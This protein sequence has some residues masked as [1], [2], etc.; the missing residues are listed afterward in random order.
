MEIYAAMI[1]EVDRH[2]GR[3]VDHLE[4]LGVADNTVIIFM[5]DNGPEG[6]DLDETWPMEAYPEIRTTIDAA[7]DFSYET[8][9]RPGSYVLYGPNWANAGSPAYRLHK[10][11]PTEGGT[12]VAAFVYD[13][14]QGASPRIV[15]DFV[16]VTDITPTILEFAGVSHP[17]SEYQGR[18]VEPAN[19]ISFA[20]LLRG[21]SGSNEVRVTGAELFGKRAVR[22]GPWKLVHMPE[23]WG[24]GDWQLYNLDE[25]L[26]ESRDLSS[27]HPEKVTELMAHWEEYAAENNVIIPDWVSGY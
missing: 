20:P 18:P 2:T 7:H 12:R 1:D 25:D 17:G 8:M 24:T 14:T 15:D 13:P 9:G 22:S 11:F 6:H 3:L 26:G 4:T 16:Y 19:G 10:A 23:P 21:E 5:S 27:A